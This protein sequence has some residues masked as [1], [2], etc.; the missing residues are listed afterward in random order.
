[1]IGPAPMSTSDQDRLDSEVSADEASLAVFEAH[2]K[3][4]TAV[5][6]GLK[7][8]PAA[9]AMNFTALDELS[10]KVKADSLGVS[11]APDSGDTPS[12]PKVEPPVSAAGDLGAAAPAPTP[13]PAPTNVPA[14][15]PTATMPAPGVSSVTE[16]P[17][18]TMIPPI[19]S[20]PVSVAPTGTPESATP[21]APDSASPAS[22]SAAA[23]PPSV[24]PPTDSSAPKS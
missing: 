4:L 6:A 11:P 24:T 7:S 14:T 22:A 3:A 5:I 16:H 1:M 2:D 17:V 19:D 13:Q 21:A 10:F 23:T 15:A 18:S 12:E 20:T 9:Q 8:Q